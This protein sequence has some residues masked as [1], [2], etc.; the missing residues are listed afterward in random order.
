MS[1]ELK[2][3][4]PKPITIGHVEFTEEEK[5]ENKRKTEALLK[6][7]GVLKEDESLDDMEHVK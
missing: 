5:R 1:E 3:G 2:K 7:M 6:R 4:I